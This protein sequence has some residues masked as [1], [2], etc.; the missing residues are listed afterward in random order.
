MINFEKTEIDVWSDNKTV[1]RLYPWL[2][3]ILPVM[4]AI[5]CC[6]IKSGFYVDEYY[7]Y[8]FANS[9]QGFSLI[10]VFDGNL[11]NRV[12]TQNDLRDY[13]IAEPEETFTYGYILDNCAQDMTPPL[14]YCI[15]HTICSFFPGEFSK[16]F[17]LCINLFAFLIILLG[18]YHISLL[19]F[20]SRWVATL[21]MFC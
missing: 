14:Y 9:S 3:C 7:S 18:L 6:I 16:W 5:Y 4:I 20:E 10:Q 8:G 17:G 2:I 12:I 11:V 13:I 15:L 21:V 1:K 19:M